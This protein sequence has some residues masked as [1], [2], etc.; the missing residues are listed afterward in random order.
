[1]RESVLKVRSEGLCQ[2]F[3]RRTLL[4]G[5]ERRVGVIVTVKSPLMCNHSSQIECYYSRGT[6]VA[7]DLFLYHVL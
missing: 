4:Y 2:P 3:E 5:T 6:E 1:M 7:A